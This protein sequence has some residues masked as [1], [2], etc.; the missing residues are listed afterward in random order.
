MRRALLA[1]LIGLAAAWAG[2]RAETVPEPDG[3]R[4]DKY[5]APAPATLAGATVLDVAAARALWEARGEA[6]GAVFIDVL[7]R[8]P[9]PA[10]LPPETVWLPP[11]HSDIPGS[12]W[13]PDVGY[14]AIAPVTEAYLRDNIA[15]AT[16]GDASRML[17]F[18][19][20]PDCWHSWNAAK[21]ALSL[22]Y[23]HVAW[24]PGG[25]AAWEH[26]GLPLE[27]REPQPRR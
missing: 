20:L 10:D 4:M 16:G 23:T 22:G 12:I 27:V 9:K 6:H 25:T 2:A 5:R 14:G 13:L 19:C 7:P 18:Y 21:R 3:Y 15:A 24:F 11:P 26:A 1:G 8:P 17:V